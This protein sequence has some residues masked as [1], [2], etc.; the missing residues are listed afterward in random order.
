MPLPPYMKREADTWD[1]ESY[2]TPHALHQAHILKSSKVVSA[3][4]CYSQI[5]ASNNFAE[6]QHFPPTPTPYTLHPAYTR[7]PSPPQRPASISRA[8]WWRR[9]VRGGW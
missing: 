8:K 6:F 5:P 9:C 4:A 7:A 2:Q 1:L 3:P